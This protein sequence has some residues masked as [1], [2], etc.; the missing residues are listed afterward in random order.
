MFENKVPDYILQKGNIIRL[1]L[2]TAIF[3]LIFINI[4][5]PFNSPSWYEV[6]EFKFF[7]FSSLI[8]LTGVLVVVISR[9]IMFRWSRNHVI[10]LGQYSIWIA[11]EIFSMSLFYTLYTLSVNPQR[12]WLTVFRESFINTA[13]VLLLPYSAIHL[14]L[15]YRESKERIRQLEEE[16]GERTTRNVVYS[17]YDEKKELR[18]SVS[19]S[20]LLYVESADN[21]V[22]I[23]Y[24]NKGQL[25]K[26]M[27]RNSLKAIEES[28]RNTSVLRCHRSYI[29]NFSQVKVI[30]RQKDGIYL[31]FGL[32]NV[33]DI[34]I[35]K[36][37]NEKV[38]RWFM[39]YSS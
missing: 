4:Y 31:E 9:V 17:F 30:R 33:P 34:P 27:L 6:S 7:V 22:Y 2:L 8:I 35:S 10:N 39:A 16:K 36:T 20:N 14:W 12:E 29:A 28:L 5:K 18:L 13:L 25:T 1:I 15:S 37:Y 19:Q 24:L 11:L 26:F 21:Y 3:A 38:T 23:W 32:E